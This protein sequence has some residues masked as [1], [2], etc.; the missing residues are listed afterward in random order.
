[1]SDA[2]GTA[3]DADSEPK[4]VV[5]LTFRWFDPN[6]SDAFTF[7]TTDPDFRKGIDAVKDAGGLLIPHADGTTWFRPWP[8]SAVEIKLV[9]LQG[10]LI[11]IP[12]P[13]GVLFGPPKLWGTP[14]RSGD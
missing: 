14:Q 12:A 1:M 13:E 6:S 5:H 11:P 9:D 3:S 2:E 10:R 7:T 8:P 4:A